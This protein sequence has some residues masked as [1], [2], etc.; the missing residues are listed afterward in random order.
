[1]Q[2]AAVSPAVSPLCN[3]AILAGKSSNHMLLLLPPWTYAPPTPGSHMQGL[4]SARLST[5]GVSSRTAQGIVNQSGSSQTAAETAE[6]WNA[7][8]VLKL[9]PALWHKLSVHTK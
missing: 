3:P 5:M 7:A 8:T 6:L 1:M 9:Q 4:S 2:S